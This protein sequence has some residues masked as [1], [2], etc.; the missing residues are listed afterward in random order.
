MA[1][2]V[3]TACHHESLCAYTIWMTSRIVF[4]RKHGNIH[5]ANKRKKPWTKRIVYSIIYCSSISCIHKKKQSCPDISAKQLQL[6]ISSWTRH[7]LKALFTVICK[8]L[9]TL[10]LFSIKTLY[11]KSST[12][13]AQQ[14]KALFLSQYQL[15]TYS[16]LA[17]RE[18]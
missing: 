4:K 1:N 2:N 15:D 8:T 5:T 7:T 9:K 12:T 6:Q 11:C 18:K 14:L 13:K 17:Y 16:Y 10:R 3:A